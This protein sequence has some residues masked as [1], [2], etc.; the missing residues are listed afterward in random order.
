MTMRA[1]QVLPVLMLVAACNE[2]VEIGQNADGGV[3]SDAPPSIPG[4]VSLQV[5][6]D[7]MEIRIEDLTIAHEVPYVATGTFVDG[8]TRD[9]TA[10]VGW[11]VDNDAP[12]GFVAAGRWRAS[13]AAGGRVVVEARAG[14]VAATADLTVVLAPAIP[15]GAFPPPPGAEGLFDPALPH[16]DGDPAGPRIVYPAHETMFPINVYRI[17]FQYDQGTAGA[18]DVW[19][20]RFVSDVLDLRVYTTSDRW[21]A[22]ELTWGFLAQSNAGGKVVMTVSSASSLTPAGPV[23]RSAPIDVFFSRSAV[24]GAIYYWSTSSEGVMKGVISQ[25][26]PTKFHSQPP[27]TTCVACHTVSR[28]G[29]RMAAGYDG[30]RL[31][32]ITIPGRQELIPPTREFGWATFSPDG[33]L[34]LY[35]NKG[36]LTLLD[37]DTGQ[38]VGPNA[39]AVPTGGALATHPDWSPQG[40]YVVVA[41]CATVGNKDASGCSIARIPYNGGAWG[42]PEILVQASGAGDNNFFPRYSPDSSLIAFVKATGKSKDQPTSELWLLPASG[43]T[44]IQLTRANHRVGPADGVAGIGNTMPTWA[45]T[46]HPGTQWLAFSSLRT[47]GKVQ[48]GADQ[49]WVVAIDPA[50]IASGDASYAAFWLPLQDVAERNHRAFWAHDAEVPCPGT[51][52]VCDEFDNDC[53]GVVDEECIPCVADETCFDGLDNDCDGEIDEGC[54]G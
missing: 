26:A 23:Y 24:E 20:V 31:Q 43:G 27:D 22:D 46:T 21:Q 9:V 39:G 2:D 47:Y 52:E 18:P 53:D 14:D 42:A 36:A 17:L 15:D 19:E 44:P 50:A 41:L 5:A 40:D 13:N 48:V 1:R 38:P 28:D 3:G 11:A 10:M 12:G 54:I 51:E 35:S 4:L 34:L 30:E 8:S 25:P 45:P 32:E 16:V 33:S 49:L 6:P 37:A 7:P 29:K